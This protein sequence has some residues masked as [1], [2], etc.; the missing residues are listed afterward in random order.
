[1][2]GI[3]GI[4][5]LDKKALTTPLVIKWMTDA[6]KHRGP[7]DEGYLLAETNKRKIETRSGELGK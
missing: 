7:D 2:C 5:G 6:I 1:M 4:I 3:C